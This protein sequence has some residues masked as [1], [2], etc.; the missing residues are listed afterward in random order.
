VA[1]ILA[2]V[3][4]VFCTKI[5]V[6]VLPILAMASTVQ[7]VNPHF[8]LHALPDLSKENNKQS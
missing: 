2:V 4:V 5:K 6:H 3:V 1:T 7:S 8:S